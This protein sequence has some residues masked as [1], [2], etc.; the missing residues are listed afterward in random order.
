[1]GTMMNWLALIIA[2]IAVAY[3]WKL[4]QEL[5]T[6]TRR[7]DRYNR[8]LFDANDEVR[9]VRE[10]MTAELAGVRAAMQLP[11][12]A[13]SFFEPQMKVRD[14]VTIHPQAEQI[15]AAFHLGGCNSCAID[16][17][18]TL[19]A[20]C[21]ENGRDLSQLLQNLNLLVVNANGQPNGA[22]PS[23]KLPNVELSF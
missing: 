7:L 19:A 17:N 11:V 5:R 13:Q 8:A 16:P 15:L 9:K 12:G 6:A 23:V 10:A 1:M 22:M 18:D 21:Q 20:V 4:H 14:A 3:A 2:L